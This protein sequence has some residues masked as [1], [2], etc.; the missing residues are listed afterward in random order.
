MID[1]E[2]VMTLLH[3]R[4]PGARICEV[5]AAANAIVGLDP[6][7]DPLPAEEMTHFHCEV[8]RDR[9]TTRDVANGTIRLYRRRGD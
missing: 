9:Y 2:K 3:K 7:F 5:A 6:E 1:R 8:G 4:F